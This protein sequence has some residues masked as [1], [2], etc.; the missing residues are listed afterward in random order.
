MLPFLGQGAANALEDAMILTRCLT[1]HSSPEQAFALYQ[2]T[3]GPRAA[4]SPSRRPGAATAIWASPPRTACKARTRARN[5]LRRGLWPARRLILSRASPAT[6]RGRGKT[7]LVQR[8]RVPYSRYSTSRQFASHDRRLGE[9]RL[10][11]GDRACVAFPRFTPW[12]PT[13]SLRL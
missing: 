10:G 9:A 12:K 13:S 7:P 3:R 2:R 6:R 4:S 11:I 5:T 8:G 1:S